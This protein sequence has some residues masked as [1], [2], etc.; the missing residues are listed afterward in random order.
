[1]NGCATE[2]SPMLK[3][4]STKKHKGI[5]R[6][7]SWNQFSNNEVEHLY[8]RYVFRIQ[9]SAMVCLALLLTILCFS[10]AVL[11]TTYVRNYTCYSLYLFIQGLVFLIFFIYMK[12]NLMKEKHFLVVNYTVLVFVVVLCIFSVPLPLW[13]PP[14]FED[15]KLNAADGAWVV[16]FIIF[17]VYALMPIR[18]LSKCICGGFIPL[19][20]ILVSWQTC[21]QFPDILWRQVSAGLS[22][23]WLVQVKLFSIT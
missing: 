16:A 5:Q 21:V 20:H 2:K 7:L 1:M 4:A 10:L 14:G 3:T 23:H 15:H 11:N 22:C 18:T 8:Q 19:V 9:Q 17:S 13:A 6:L 12:A